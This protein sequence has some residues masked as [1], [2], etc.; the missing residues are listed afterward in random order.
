M[1]ISTLLVE[2]F[3][4]FVSSI[5]LDKVLTKLIQSYNMI[6]PSNL[7]LN[8]DKKLYVVCCFA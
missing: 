4:Q 2:E 7:L 3:G 1:L 5:F 6:A 8:E